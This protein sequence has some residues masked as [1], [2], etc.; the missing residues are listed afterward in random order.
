MGLP[1]EHGGWSLT[2]EPVVLGMLVSASV[3]GV[4]LAVAAVLAFL[5]RT[6]LRV[7]LVDHRRRRRLDRTMLAARLAGVEGAI[8]LVCIAV[9]GLAASDPFWWPLVVA[10]PLVLV[11]LGYDMRS[12][13]RRLVPELSGAVGIG[14]AAAAIV[15]AG[16][17]EATVA[18]ALWWVVAARAA[19]S[20]PFVRLQ[21]E[22]AKGRPHRM[23]TSDLAQVLTVVAIVPGWLVGP[24][25]GAAVVA[26]GVLAAV[27]LVLVRMP[28]PV[29]AVVGAQQVVL[30][31][32]VVVTTALAVLAP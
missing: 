20:L 14:S 18:L 3:A 29:A 12:R 11:E 21:L 19:A 23:W 16:G 10:A 7:V 6:P 15:V 31:L 22:R 8:L 13:G 2:L 17:G 32:G 26:V 4:A 9:A 30:G 28:A 24:V 5:A 27:Q 25:P 1:R